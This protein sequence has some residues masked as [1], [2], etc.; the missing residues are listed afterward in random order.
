MYPFDKTCL[1]YAVSEPGLWTNQLVW[2][3]LGGA[4]AG[5]V[6]RVVHAFARLRKSGHIKPSAGLRPMNMR[7]GCD[8]FYEE[9][10]R[11]YF[12]ICAE[13]PIK[14]GDLAKALG[15][16][17]KDVGRIA[18][19]LARWGLVSPSGR[20]WP[21][22]KGLDVFWDHACKFNRSSPPL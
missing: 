12:V 19:K 20:I 14:H 16:N 5:R 4:E 15:M 17:R 9:D 2:K 18:R 3:D 6:D 1:S 11:V 13:Q 21:T 10:Q 8:I 7:S 22:Q